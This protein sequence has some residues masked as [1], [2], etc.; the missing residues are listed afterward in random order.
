MI[1]KVP[2]PFALSAGAASVSGSGTVVFSN[3]N[4]VS[5]GANGSTITASVAPGGG[6]FSAQ[7]GSST[8]A[9]LSFSN[10]NGATFSNS[11]GQVALSYTVPSTVGLISALKISAGTL[12]SNR[13][14]VTFADSNGVSFGL[15]T[16]GVV[17]ATVQ[18]NYL[19]TAMASNRGSDFVQAAA[20]FAGTNASG[21]IASGGV[22]VSVG[23]YITTARASSDAVG[24]NTA[25]TNVTWTVNSSGL[26]L[27]AGGYAGTGFTSTTTAGT[28][29]VG[30]HNTAGLS[31]GVP[32]YLTAAAGGFSAGVS[33]VGNTSGQTG[34]TG[35]RIVFAGGNN[36][37]VSQGTDANGATITI[38]GANAGGAQTGISGIVVSNTT[39][40]SGT[41]SFSNANGAS[42]GSSAG[43]AIT[44]SYTVP[45]LTNSSLTMQAGASTLS[46]VSRI[47]FVDSNGVSFGASTSNNGSITITATVQTNYL[48]TA[49]LSQNSSDY[50]RNWKLTGNTAGTT[51]SKQGTD[52]WLAGGNGVTVS[53][54]SNTISISVANAPAA[55]SWTVSDAVT[56]QTIG[57]LAFTNANGLTMTLSTS[58]NGN[59]TVFGSYT[60]PIVT[61][62]SM[63]VSDAATSGTLARLAFTNING[64]TLSLSTGAGGSHT[65]VGS[66]NAVTSQSNQTG[67][68]YATS[69]TFGTSS[70]TYG[71]GTLSI[72]GS[73]EIFVAASNS[74]WV[75]SAPGQSIG[76]STGGGTSGNTGTYAGQVVFAGGNNVTLSVSSGA[77]GVQ[78][79]SI[80]VFNQSNQTVG[81]YVTGNS[82]QNSFTT[83]DARSLSFNAST[84]GAVSMGFSNGSI[85]VSA[86]QTSSLSAT[87]AF[88]ISTNGGTIS[89]GVQPMNLYGVGNT[90]GTSSG[91]ADL[92]TISI[93]GASG[94]QVAASN[95]GYVV[96][97]VPQSAFEPF[98]I[99]TGTAYSS[100]APASWWFN[101]VVVPLPLAISNLNVV[102]SLSVA[103]PVTGVASSGTQKYSYSHGVTVFSRQNYGAQ[104]SNFTTLTTAS[105]G[106]TG[107]LSITSSSV[108]AAYSYV[109]NTTGGTTS[110]STAFNGA[111]FS[112]WSVYFSG[113]FQFQIPLLTTLQAGEYFVAHNHSST[114]ATGGNALF[115]LSS[116][117]LSVSNLHV[118]PQVVGP[119]QLPGQSVTQASLNPFGMGAG[120]ASAVTTNNS[121][122]GSAVSGQTQNNWYFA[123]SNA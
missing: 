110:F 28:A 15:N 77:A 58:N 59:A 80:S 102:K 67:N 1:S 101:R 60:V 31:L 120:V 36:V 116:V 52:F 88:S 56:S 81:L 25:K 9:T 37:T 34:I 6:A 90:F 65:V 47:A 18:T 46:S 51:S 23:N 89:M 92:R 111:S 53:G 43:Q 103:L 2:P 38:S 118:A 85:L 96:G 106:L 74:G 99:L 26:S 16:N 69:N 21:T 119:L 105:F 61:N 97:H 8:F 39:Y 3:S 121:M 63:T 117:L 95:S 33:N 22:S 87:G 12:S 40:T 76:V 72:Q 104:S 84:A 55:T 30:T 115:A 27:D 11:G 13:S 86:P 64:V 94:V 14:D 49:D 100:H 44:L 50:V 112:S 45:T 19:T 24:L 32:V 20:V 109:T 122:A 79:I 29:I 78:T 93:S 71:A 5:F 83:I 17:T 68:V 123:A 57:R 66:H 73:G 108:S 70:G 91:T 82:V 41:V 114:A 113:P 10:A 7:G 42:F 54:S 4:G 98:P 107:S 75:I 35:T 62:S 48:T